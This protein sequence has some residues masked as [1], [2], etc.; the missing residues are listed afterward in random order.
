LDT[1]EYKSF[2]LKRGFPNVQFPFK[3]SFPVCGLLLMKRTEFTGITGFKFRIV[4]VGVYA[5]IL[6][7][8]AVSRLTSGNITANIS[9]N[10]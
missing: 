10:C 3:V 2:L 9:R 8:E 1:W 6:Q 7:M 4:S 5:C